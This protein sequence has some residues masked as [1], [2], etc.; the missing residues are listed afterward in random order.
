[1]VKP[2][3]AVGKP[4]APKTMR[5]SKY[6]TVYGSLKPKHTAGTKPVRVYKYKKVNGKWVSKGYVKAT[7]SN[8]STYSRYK[9]RMRLTSKGKWRLRAYAPADSAHAASWSG[10]YDYVTVK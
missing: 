3:A 6:Y 9:V 4:V 8:F 1:V 5:R 2:K 7:A 10:G